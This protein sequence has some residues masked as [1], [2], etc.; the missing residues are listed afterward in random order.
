MP[1]NS[2]AILLK[3]ISIVPRIALS[4]HAIKISC[5]VAQQQIGVQDLD[6]KKE[7]G[8]RHTVA[9]S[10]LTSYDESNY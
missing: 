5:L 8:E 4:V 9:A 6:N 3:S 1:S 10:L 2:Q 7:I